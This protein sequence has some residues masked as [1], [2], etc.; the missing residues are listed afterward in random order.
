MT[1]RRIIYGLTLAVAGLAVTKP[2]AGSESWTTLPV[3]GSWEKQ[4]EERRADYDGFAWYRCYVKV[5]GRWIAENNSRDLWANSLTLAVDSLT[6]AYEVFLNGQRIGGAGKLPPEY[7][8]GKPGYRRHSIPPGLF[9]EGRNTVAIRVYNEEGPGGFQG[10]A[11]ILAGYFREIRLE[12]PWEF[13]TGDDVDW[14]GG[15]KQPLSEKVVYD[16]DVPA[17]APLQRPAELTHGASFTPE[18]ALDK[19]ET[20]E[21][22]QVEQVLSEP[23]IAQP[24]ALSFD[25][26]GRLWVVEYRQYPWPAG[27]TMKS[28][29][30]YYRAVYDRELPPPPY[31]KDSRFRGRDRISI[32]EDTDGDGTFDTHTTFAEGLN[33]TTAVAQGD[34]GVW[35]LSPPQLLFYPDADRDDVPDGPPE[36][37]LTG[38]GLEDTHSVV[39]SLTWGPDGWL[40]AAQGSTVTARVRQPGSDA[41]PVYSEG[42]LIWRYHPETRRYEIFAEGGGNAFSVE[43]DSQGRLFS[44]HNGGD[45][46]GFHYMQGGYYSKGLSGKYGPMSNPYTFGLLPAMKAGG[47]IQRFSHACLLYEAPSLPERYHGKLF[48]ADPLHNELILAERRRDGSTFATRDRDRPLRTD[49][50]AFRPVALALGPDGAVYVADFYNFYIAHGQHYSG[51]IDPTTGRVYRLRGDS[52]EVHAPA[53]LREKS[54]NELI[55]RLGHGN[56]R[57]RRTALRLLGQRRDPSSVPRLKKLLHE[58]EGQLALEALWALHLVGHFDEKL[59]RQG[60]DHPNPHV[61]QWT[62][63]LAGDDGEVSDGFARL[64]PELAA[65]E[66]NAEVRSQLACTARRLPAEQGLPLIRELLQRGEDADDAQI[67]LLLWWALEDKCDSDR[68]AVLELFAEHS[69]WRQP[70]VERHILGRLMRRYAEGGRRDDLLTCARLLDLAPGRELKQTLLTGLEKALEGRSLSDAPQKLV[71]EIAEAGGGSLVLRLRQR[72]PEAIEQALEILGDAQTDPAR[73][74]ELARVFSEVRVDRSVPVLW[75]VVQRADR[76]ALR[77]AALGALA[78]YGDPEIGRRVVRLYPELPEDLRG[79]AARLLASRAEWA[80]QLL[81]AIE[82]GRIGPEALPQDVVDQLRLHPDESLQRRVAEIWGHPREERSETGNR[83]MAELKRIIDSGEGNLYRGKR[84]FAE[85][86]GTCHRLFGDGDEIGPDLTAF[87]RTDT[88]RMLKNI[89]EPSAEIREGFETYLILTEGGRVVSGFPVERNEQSVVL[90]SADGQDV[91][92]PRERIDRMVRQNKSL[93]PED[94]LKSLSERDVRDLFAYLQSGQP[95]PD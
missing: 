86:C 82:R 94:V 49:D 57:V 10:P 39:N 73:R 69:L 63:R 70:L 74:R 31:E 19:F 71:D 75:E 45:T 81:D 52:S 28:R 59:A 50:P 20:A 8:P 54:T 61:R 40:Y 95:V 6:D 79:T 51:K 80:G 92:I 26:R 33:I 29:D 64:L 32:H 4:A 84:L 27:L 87:D 77:R 67:P 16:Q 36:V 46:R 22:L 56:R 68:E 12:G 41:E 13:R 7:R 58:R 76:A 72:Q 43:I 42:P 18:E 55:D 17:T 53:D 30:K 2:A 88:R 93:M 85:H 62:V 38:F 78:S 60:L 47:P 48:C 23:T 89:V 9:R 66:P 15:G 3:P 21:D 25:A 65:T 1:T 34:G 90:R 35:V 83:G 24:V 37:H 5:P 91:T 44:G 14:A 11:P